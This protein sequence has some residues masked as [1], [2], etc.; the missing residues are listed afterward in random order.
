[1]SDK[2][3]VGN[4][5]VRTY[6][7]KVYLEAKWRDSG[8]TQRAKRLGLAWLEKDPAG[9][10]VKKSGR[11]K[12]GYLDDRR[13]HV[14]MAE[15]IADHEAELSCAPGNRAATFD[16]AAAKWLNHLEH[17]LR[18]KPSTLREY[19]IM[20][21]DPDAPRKPRASDGK[22]R[23]RIL[24]AFGGQELAS[25]T[26]ADVRRFLAGMDHEDISARTVNRH[27][28]LLH[29][30]FEYGKEQFGLRENPVAG[31]DKRPEMDPAPIDTFD[32]KE[33]KLIA[34]AARAGL[35]RPRPDH[36]Y[37]AETV[38]EWQR[39]NQQDADMYTVAAFTGLR[40]G[41]LLALRWRDID[42]T[43]KRLTVERAVSAGEEMP[44]TK[45][46]HIRT[47]PIVGP[48]A[49]AFQRLQGRGNFTSRDDRVFCRTDGGALDRT[50][51]RKR[52]I[53]CQ[54]HAKVRVRRFHDLRHSF[55]SMAINKFDAVKVQ[56]YMGHASLS[57]TERYMH[58]KSHAGDAAKLEEAF[59][60]A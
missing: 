51:V 17:A 40:L 55:G 16:D 7:N 8:R 48:V 20:L 4:L 34:T 60:A 5:R 45:S 58:A 19:K 29:S 22:S 39:L 23:A 1:M 56:H 13:A 30:V 35:H 11:V 6:K 32:P 43:R 42:L 54:E 49:D 33:V 53:K 50:S 14:L 2:M 25:I 9:E 24:K 57:T 10:W 3:S 31:T 47:V 46:R 52:F 21:A 15:V 36:D 12:P 28:Q 27:R 41:E 44:S 26:A 37:S 18:I 38:A 59:S